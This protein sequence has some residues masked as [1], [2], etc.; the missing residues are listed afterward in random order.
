M[1]TVAWAPTS[2]VTRSQALEKRLDACALRS[3]VTPSGS[4]SK[5]GVPQQ[6]VITAGA[7]LVKKE[8]A[9]P[10]RSPH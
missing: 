9:T 8:L 5:E 10:F 7:P 1:H 3:T 6:P 4:P 2:G